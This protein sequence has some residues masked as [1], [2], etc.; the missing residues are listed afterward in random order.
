[1]FKRYVPRRIDWAQIIQQRLMQ[2]QITPPMVVPPIAAEEVPPTAAEEVPP[3]SGRP[4]LPDRDRR[5]EREQADSDAGSAET[6]RT[7]S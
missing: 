2:P 1:M 4:E 7:E 6:I 3:E 5:F